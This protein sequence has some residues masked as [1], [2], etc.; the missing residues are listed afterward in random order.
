MDE[1]KRSLTTCYPII[2]NSA[3]IFMALTDIK[4]YDQRE[5]E[6]SFK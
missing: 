3:K 2:H 1:K 5:Q 6:V 4:S